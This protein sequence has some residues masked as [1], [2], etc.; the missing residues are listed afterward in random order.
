MHVYYLITPVNL[1]SCSNPGSSLIS[2]G[3]RYLISMPDPHAIFLSVSNTN[4]LERDWRLLLDQADCLILSGGSLYDPNDISTYWND[5][6]WEHVS[7]ALSHNIPFADLFGYTSYPFPLLPIDQVIADILSQ[8]RTQRVLAVQRN[9]TLIVPRD[10][11]TQRIASTVLPDVQALPCSSF[12]SPDF[13]NIKPSPPKYN[14]ITVSPIVTDRWFADALFSI[15]KLLSLELPTYFIFHS[16]PDYYWFHSLYPELTNY[17]C[18]YDPVSLLTFYS[19]CDKVVSTRLHAAI[20]AYA[21]GCKVI[22][23]SFDSRS[24]AL[25]QFGVHSVPYLELKDGFFPKNW[26]HLSNNIPPDPSTFIDLFRD[27]IVSR[28][29]NAQ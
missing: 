12:W 21:L 25:E 24:F 27:R 9:S 17:T 26:E 5:F 28:L 11:L 6:V 7:T 1:E 19:M 18:L 23:F 3:L 13:F 8:P 10:S 4:Y 2:Y 29:D 22:Y 20:P 15:Y 16:H 14:C